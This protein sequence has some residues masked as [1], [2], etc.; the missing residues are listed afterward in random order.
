MKG[1]VRKGYFVLHNLEHRDIWS[2]S[3]GPAPP[4]GLVVDVEK[5][6]GVGPI[7]RQL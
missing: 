5:K 7:F 4:M 2:I 3:K 6:G 1:W